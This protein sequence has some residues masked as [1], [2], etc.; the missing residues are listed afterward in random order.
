MVDKTWVHLSRVDPGYERGALKFVRDVA[1]ALGGIDMIVCPCI[2]CR[3]ID[4]HSGSVVVDHLVTRGMEEGYKMRADWYLHGELNSDIEGASRASEW[5]DEIFGL[6]RAAECFDEELANTGD[7]SDKAEGDDKKEDEFLAKLADAET[8]LYPSCVNHIKLSAIVSLLRVKTQNG[9]SDK[10]FN[11]LLET[12]P[13]MLPEENVLHTSL[14]DVKKFLKSFD[15][16]YEKIH[17]CVNDCC[18]FRKRFKK[19]EKCPKCKASRWKTNMHTGEKKKGVPQKV[20]RYFPIIPRLKRLFRSEEMAKNLRWH[21]SNKSSDGKLRHPVDSVTWDQMNAKYPAFA[22]EERNLRLGLSTDGFNPFNMKNSMYSC[23]PVLVV[24]YNLPP[25]LYMKK[26][27][28]MLSLLIPGPHQPGN[29]I[30]VYLEPLID[31]LNSLWNI[32]ELTYDALTRSTF[33]LKA[34]LLWT[35]SDFPAYRNLAGCKVKG[36]MGCPLCGKK[37]DSMWLKFSRKHVYMCHRKGLPPTHSF[38]GKKKWFDGK[39][40]QGRRG[41]ILTGRD[42]SQHLRNFKNEF[43]NFKG[44]ASK[45]KRLQCS[46]NLGSDSEVLSSESEEEEDEEVQ[47]DEDELSRWK[48]RSI[49]FKLPYWEELPVRHNLDVM[50]VERNVAASLVSMLLHCGKSKAGLAARK[51]LEELGIRPELH[52]KIQGKRTYLP[53]APWS[54]S[55]AEKKIFC[56]RLFD[57]KGPNGY[58]SN[59]SR[60]VSL[61]DYKVTGLKSH[62]YHVL[63]QQL[64]PIALK[65]LLP[66]GP[67][68][69]VFRLCAFF[70]LLCQRVIDKEKLLVMEAEIVETLCLFERFF[71][72]SFFDIMLHLTVHLG[73]EARLGGPV[74]FRWMYPFERY[75][76]VLKDYVRNP[77]RPEGCIAECYLAEECIRFCS[78]F[79]KKTTNVQEKVDRNIEYENNSIL[80]GRPISIGTS[81]TLSESD[82]GIAHL[83]IIQNMAL[84]DPYVDIYK[85]QMEDAGE[86]PQRYGVP[87]D[88]TEH[89][90]TLKWIAYGPRCSARSSAKDTSQ[91]VDLVSYYGRVTYFILVDYNIFYVPLFRCQWAVKG[92]GVKMEDGFTLV[93]MN[94]NQASFASGPYILA[95]QAKQVFYSREDESSNWYIV[96]KVPSRRYSKED[97]QEGT[98]DIGLLPSNIDMDADIDEAE[99]ARTDCEGIYV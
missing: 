81:I 52:P 5:N 69:A 30:D 65:E 96:M 10:S 78:D 73:R 24:N 47:V 26:E 28:I 21:F 80:E 55:K 58:C 18:L 34:M 4:R 40:E 17:A 25:D 57:F 59:I 20:L 27:N 46:D 62:D 85:T 44:S 3:N 49:F 45:R 22:A 64:L 60:G 43:G 14:Y 90:K 48:K 99:N 11:D 2:D 19:L 72:P 23:W 75:M 67:R 51:D 94:H 86:M 9:W 63:M 13:E 15:M 42:I 88:S 74:H 91:V 29:S 76:K 92:N 6:Y 84:V 61:D 95:S 93:N 98:A 87:L 89:D 66:K 12:L 31:D 7:L 79:L 50:H 97:I 38:R 33:T 39:T 56:R 82:I 35:I 70:N 37:T 71:P 68:L 32:G 8:P 53:P 77:A 36:K 54:L 83:A 1:S 41:R 16:G